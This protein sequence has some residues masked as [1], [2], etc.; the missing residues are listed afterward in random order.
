MSDTKKIKKELTPA[1]WQEESEELAEEWAKLEDSLVAIHNEQLVQGVSTVSA[2]KTLQHQ[3]VK[4]TIK[5]IKDTVKAHRT[6]ID[7][8]TKERVENAS[9]IGVKLVNERFKSKQRVNPETNIENALKRNS[10]YYNFL[11]EKHSLAVKR[12]P[13][14]ISAIV[15]PHKYWT[16]EQQTEGLYNAIS[17]TLD[18]EL[19]KMVGVT[20]QNGRTVSF[21]TYM[22]MRIRT[23]LNN[24]ALDAMTEATNNLGIVFFLCNTWGDS[25]NDHAH[26]QGKV[27]VKRD[28]RSYVPKTR[29]EEFERFISKNSILTVEEVTQDKPYLCTRPNCRHSLTPITYEQAQNASNTLKEL[30]L[31]NNGSYD[32][33]KYAALQKKGAL[34]RRIRELKL[35]KD[36]IER[37]IKTCKS[38]TEKQKLTAQLHQ[39]NGKIRENQ[40]NIRSLI[41]SNSNL[42]RRYRRENPFKMAYNMAV[43]KPKK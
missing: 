32:K 4:K 42:E 19:P 18:R 41:A 20:Y 5:V 28:W 29:I 37:S 43:D 22:E 1:E 40:G 39:L 9:D 30:N 13:S 23:D 7:K 11:V 24:V 14:R 34:E 27:Y 15:G 10:G 6:K 31:K 8:L 17:K 33:A 36:V 35:K 26:Y 12:L 2:Y 38:E 25:A 3:I 21:R 16:V